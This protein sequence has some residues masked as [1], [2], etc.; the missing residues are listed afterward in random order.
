MTF[1]LA[2]ARE[3]AISRHRS[4]F[5]RLHGLL[6]AAREQRDL[7]DTGRRII[8]EGEAVL[9]LEA[10]RIVQ[11]LFLVTGRNNETVFVIGDRQVTV[12]ILRHFLGHAACLQRSEEHTS[13]L[14]SQ[15]NLV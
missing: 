4:L 9:T 1:P 3:W 5:S 14:Q 15:S 11:A 10:V 13:E 2:V 6:A 8:A 7:A 12:H